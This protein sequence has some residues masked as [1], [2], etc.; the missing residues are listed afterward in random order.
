MGNG[1]DVFPNKNSEC[2][3][4]LKKLDDAFGWS[5]FLTS[6]I[7]PLFIQRLNNSSFVV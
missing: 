4:A 3:H 5:G 2:R 7:I 6:D 1:E